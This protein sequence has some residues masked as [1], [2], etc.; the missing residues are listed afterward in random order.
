VVGADRDAFAAAV[1]RAQGYLAF[2]V[3]R[4][5]AARGSR[6][7]VY[8]RVQAVLSAAPASV[9]RA[10][11]VRLV[12]DRLGLPADL[13]AALTVPSAAPSASAGRRV[14]RSARELDERLFLGMCFALGAQADTF[15]ATL[16]VADFTDTSLWEAA[17]Y[18]R[19]D[20]A[21]EA[22]SEEAHSWAPLKAEL[23]A[24]AAREGPSLRVLEELYWKLKLHSVEAT[25]KNLRESADLGISQ[26]ARLQELQQL[27]LS[28][29]ER[30]EAVRSQAPDQ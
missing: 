8:G 18:A 25:L 5:L 20:V 16:D 15:L 12:T 4:L 2:R 28:H 7:Q 6:D 29:L 27:R 21:G 13:A 17:T 26:Q 10:E 30:L 19:R 24:L 22:S 1:E 3:G 9:E 11:Q 23:D 14:R